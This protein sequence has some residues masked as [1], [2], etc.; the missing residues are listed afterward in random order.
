MTTEYDFIVIGAGSAGCALAARLG[1]TNAMVLCLEA[2]SW[3]VT[4]QVRADIERPAHW[5]MVLGTGADWQ[6]KSTPQEHLGDDKSSGRVVQEPRGKLPG[7]SSNLYAMMHIRGDASDFDHWAYSG[8]PGWSYGDVLPYFQKLEDYEDDSNP[9]GGKG[10]PLA[11]S[12]ARL[13]QPSPASQAFIHACV[14]LSFPRTEDFNGPQM[15]GVGWHHA[16]IKNGKRHDMFS[17]YLAPA[18][19]RSNVT[20]Q[21][22][23]QATR[24][25]FDGER[26]IGVEFADVTAAGQRKQVLARREVIVC[27]GAIESPK[28]LLLSGIGAPDLLKTFDLPVISALPG[29][30]E[31]FH[32]HVLAP[33]SYRTKFTLPEPHFNLSEAAMFYRS[34]PGWVGPDMQMAF[35]HKGATSPDN[36]DNE[37]VFLPGVVRPMSRGWVGLNSG[38]PLD[39]PKI[40]AN[41]L[42]AAADRERLA[43]AMRLA[44]R[45]AAAR[46]FANILD[47]RMWPPPEV[48]PDQFDQ[49]AQRLADSYHHQAGSCKMG[50]DG[51]AV[52][53]PVLRV[54][55]VRGLR[56]V[57]AS[58][59]PVVPSGNCHA[60]IVMIAEKAADLIKNAH[61]LKTL[62]PLPMGKPA[63][64]ERAAS[65]QSSATQAGGASNVAQ[66]EAGSGAKAAMP[67]PSPTFNHV[68]FAIRSLW[69]GSTHGTSGSGGLA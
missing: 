36:E 38:D 60:A 12:S 20:L 43:E 30:G 41:Y 11:V 57:D 68:A 10:G 13:H 47:A 46:A 17:A 19:A 35:V 66:S 50:S 34:S 9:L 59:M 8:C 53:D 63:F 42:A 18:L 39:R 26:C 21:C 52:V 14:E 69:S 48:G 54:Y 40:N 65:A 37:V 58:V 44:A 3:D 61:G 55:G 64:E 45:I 2:G 7:G 27:A 67:A 15:E 24:L 49:W 22:D 56:V 6:Y 31:N 28:L 4:P 62:Q 16:N 29:V 25:L 1:E 23:A 51:L 33:L 32:N 5:G